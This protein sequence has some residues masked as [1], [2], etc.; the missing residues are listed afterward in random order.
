MRADSQAVQWRLRATTFLSSFDRFAI[1]PLLVPI[2]HAFGV[3]LGTAALVARTYFV[4]YGLSQPFWGARSDRIGRVQVIWFAISAGG[5]L[6]RSPLLTHPKAAASTKAP[7]AS[8][9]RGSRRRQ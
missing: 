2:S 9:R 5:A 7:E 8:R 1:P 4:A 6:S 3:P